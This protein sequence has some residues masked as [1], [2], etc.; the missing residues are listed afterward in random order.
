MAG[1]ASQRLDRWLWCARF[2]RSRSLA[3]KLC[4]GD[5][6]TVGGTTVQKAH[7]PVRVGDRLTL[8]L[9]RFERQVEVRALAERRGPASEARALYAETAPPLP[10]VEVAEPWTSLFAEE[11]EQIAPM[12]PSP[13]RVENP[14]RPNGGRAAKRIDVGV[15]G[16]PKA[17]N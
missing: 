5:R 16:A 14:P 2:V 4:T 7:H 15:R 1:D 13:D 17:M 11:E 9:R 10:L 8:R 6:V 3:A 12:Q